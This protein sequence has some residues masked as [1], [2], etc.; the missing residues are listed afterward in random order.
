MKMKDEITVKKGVNLDFNKINQGSGLRKVKVYKF[1]ELM[2]QDFGDTYHDSDDDTMELLTQVRGLMTQ[3]HDVDEFEK[4]M[5]IYKK[6]M[7]SLYELYGGKKRF[8]MMKSANCVKEFIPAKPILKQTKRLNDIY[9]NGLINSQVVTNMTKMQK[10]KMVKEAV[11]LGRE[12]LYMFLSQY[13]DDPTELTLNDLTG[14]ND[15][16]LF[17]EHGL[18]S[19][20]IDIYLSKHKN[21]MHDHDLDAVAAFLG[22]RSKPSSDTQELLKAPTLIDLFSS[23]Y[24]PDKF[25]KKASEIKGNKHRL[26]N[27]NGRFVT[28]SAKEDY[29]IK[30][31]IKAN[32]GIDW[33]EHIK[34]MPSVRKNLAKK[35]MKN[36]AL[37]SYFNM[38]KKERK[39]RKKM[40]KSLHED[41]VKACQDAIMSSANELLGSNFKSYE[42]Y[43]D[44]TLSS[45]NSHMKKL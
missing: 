21:E 26:V 39:Q 42:E 11:E 37:S 29:E 3:Y 13:Y 28:M 8:K 25:G 45:I 12:N 9:Y 19:L 31:M 35:N 4:A 15:G 30:Q 34:K 14:G 1:D 7:K 10:R 23:D 5:D 40:Q 36:S 32:L 38:T 22:E 27:M 24:D 17:N 43:M 20:C 2:V 33:D 16:S 44:S 18:T 6:Y 41:N